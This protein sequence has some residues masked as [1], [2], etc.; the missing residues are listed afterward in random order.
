VALPRLLTIMGSGETAPTMMKVHRSIKEL[1]GPEASGV[2]LDT[3]Y[4]FQR[5]ADDLSARAVAY[6]R[7]SV[8]MTMTPSEFRTSEDLDGD[9]G[10]VLT[11]RMAETPLLFSGPG[12]PT[13]AL[14]QWAGTLVP[15]LL[16]EKLALGGA[17]TFAS[18]A[19]LTLGALTIPVYE[20]YK[21]GEDPRWVDG[22]DLMSGL[23][24]PAVVI[25]HYD[26]AEGGTHDTRFCYLGEER[27]E[28]LERQ[29][30]EGDF[31]LG[32][33]EH[34]AVTFDL[35]SAEATI[36]GRGHITIRVKGNSAV[37]EAGVVVPTSYLLELAA[38]LAEGAESTGSAGRR[39]AIGGV[40]AK[41]TDGSSPGDI[42]SETAPETAST[43]ATGT[44]L[45][46][47]IR[48][49]EAA[50]RS[51]RAA[52]DPQAMVTAALDLNDELWAWVADPN[53]S[54]EL[55]RG[56]AALRAMIV[57]L[58]SLAG[59]SMRD[60][61]ELFGPFVDLLVESR[62]LAREERRFAE[63]DAVRDQLAALG[64]ELHDT[65]EG[66]TWDRS[67]NAERVVQSGPSGAN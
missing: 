14:R 9:K 41:S 52:P 27:L 4:G 35:D 58:G 45:L 13:Y 60:P 50:F 53:Q 23:G 61:A 44:P 12:S 6:F 19:A 32:V 40:D 38:G 7:D 47:A 29:I 63:A 43:G 51:A 59:E 16:A 39:P 10:A 48:S 36:A 1:L 42:R 46:Q 56:R 65:P 24:I 3:P 37:V 30:P 55:D 11:A 18:A 20:I 31:V 25:P 64:I 67:G 62:T 33:D 8:G 21:V 57:E 26:N 66:S 22:L 49:Y 17:V 15:G 2:L 34:T 54:D 28:H 5:N